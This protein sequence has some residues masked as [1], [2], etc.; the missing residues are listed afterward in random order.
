MTRHYTPVQKQTS[1]ARLG[2]G[3]S[4]ASALGRD[5][6][7][8]Y[9]SDEWHAEGLHLQLVARSER[10][11]CGLYFITNDDRGERSFSYRRQH[12]AASM[13]IDLIGADALLSAMTAADLVYFSLIT[14]AILSDPQREKLIEILRRAHQSGVQI[15]FD[16]NYRPSLWH[17]A[18]EARFWHKQALR[19]STLG[20]P[21]LQDDEA[22]GLANGCDAVSSH[23]KGCG[24]AEMAIKIGPEGVVIDGGIL[25][26]PALSIDR[27]VDT[28]GAGDAFNAGYLA[29]RLNG[30]S[31]ETAAGAGNTLAGWVID[32]RGAVPPLD[33]ATYEAASLRG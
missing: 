16:N 23:W 9:L 7:S 11:E 10:A 6:F 21:T 32:Q 4:L 33:R 8:E 20:L 24:V 15:A 5:Q 1:L 29:A 22:L 3:T 12:S 14:L 26:S 13:M 25:I 2:L 28:S 18:N 19:V 30:R 31:S 27:P 17:N